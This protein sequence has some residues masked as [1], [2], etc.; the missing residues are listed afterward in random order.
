MQRLKKVDCCWYC[1]K[2]EECHRLVTGEKDTKV[3]GLD[4]P[5]LEACKDCDIYIDFKPCRDFS[6]ERGIKQ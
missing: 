4:H 2:N 3:C 6:S 5:Y 1:S